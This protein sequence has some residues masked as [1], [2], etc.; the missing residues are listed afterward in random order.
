[1]YIK[2]LYDIQNATWTPYVHLIQNVCR[3]GYLNRFK[4][5]KKNP[6]T[7]SKKV[8][9]KKC[10]RYITLTENK[11]PSSLVFLSNASRQKSH[12][13]PPTVAL[14]NY[15]MV[16][17]DQIR[18]VHDQNLCNSS[19]SEIKFYCLHLNPLS[20]NITKW[21]NTLKQF[22]D[23]M[24]TN[25]LSVFDH[26]V[27][28]AL[29]GLILL[30]PSCFQGEWKETNGMKWVNCATTKLWLSCQTIHT[31]VDSF[32]LR[33]YTSPWTQDVRWTYVRRSEDILEI[34]WTSYISSVEVLYPELILS[35]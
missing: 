33:K 16:P 29:K 30:H 6:N 15:W 9:F 17:N 4:T 22:V 24:P 13:N 3:L 10:R 34:F 14:Q 18:L 35:V 25:C 11:F 32:Y 7:P 1:M 12:S 23:K 8:D 27:G 28:L 2:R 19:I 26:F 5:K 31:A 21:S 20:A